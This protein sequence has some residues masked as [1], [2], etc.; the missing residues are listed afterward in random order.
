MLS[1]VSYK[2][3]TLEHVWNSLFSARAPPSSPPP[4]P[5]PPGTL[6]FLYVSLAFPLIFPLL[7]YSLASPLSLYLCAVMLKCPSFILPVWCPVESVTRSEPC[8]CLI[9]PGTLPHSPHT[10]LTTCYASRHY[11]W[12]GYL[13]RGDWLCPPLLLFLFLLPFLFSPLLLSPQIFVLPLSLYLSCLSAPALSCPAW[14]SVESVTSCEP[15]SMCLMFPATS[16]WPGKAIKRCR[17]GWKLSTR[18]HIA[19]TVIAVAT[20]DRT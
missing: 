9:F 11:N 17:V 10:H 4:P 3:W 5:P 13:G 8:S 14:C 7:S 16:P 1:R 18:P 20:W 12:Q 19:S 6:L 2:L 15:W